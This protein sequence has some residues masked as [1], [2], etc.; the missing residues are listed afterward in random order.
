MHLTLL[1]RPGGINC[2]PTIAINYST[3]SVSGMTKLPV[4]DSPSD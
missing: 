3:R 2:D 1:M 4:S